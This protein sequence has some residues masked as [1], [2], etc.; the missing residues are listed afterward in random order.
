[1]ALKDF[2]VYVDQTENSL[3]R[4]RLAVDLAVRNDSRLTAIYVRESNR[5][6]LDLR[7][8]AELGLVSAAGLTASTGG[9]KHRSMR[10]RTGCDR[11]WKSWREN[12]AW[13][14]NCAHRWRGFPR[15]SPTR[16]LCRS[17]ILGRD[18]PEGR[19]SVNYT[20]AEQLLFVTGRPVYSCPP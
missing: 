19:A 18:Q 8:A 4:L 3:V 6:Q 20:F 17:L 16:A 11:H 5:D 12:M 15:G 14:P 2:L 10:W 9:S 1:M 7:K 13:W